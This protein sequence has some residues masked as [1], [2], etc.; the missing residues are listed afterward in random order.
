MY[1]FEKNWTIKDDNEIWRFITYPGVMPKQYE[2]SSYGKI[3]N[4]KTG[5]ELKFTALIRNIEYENVYYIIK[6]KEDK[7][8]NNKEHYKNFRVNRLVAWEFCP[9]RDINLIVGH[10]NDNKFDNYYKNLK[11][12]TYGENTRSAIESGALNIRGINN[13]GSVYKEKLIHKICKMLED[14]KTNKEIFVN[15]CGNIPVRKNPSI[16]A[17][18]IHL[19]AKD[20]HLNICSKYKYSPR[21]SLSGKYKKIFKLLLEGKENIDIMKAMGFEKISDDAHMYG[22]ILRYRNILKVYEKNNITIDDDIV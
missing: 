11:W 18:I 4:N 1:G 2:V 14:G 17:L 20:R 22:I 21:I 8:I 19:H 7:L 3:R 16:Y 9:N 5:K 10:L 13:S 12:M 6:L 15:I